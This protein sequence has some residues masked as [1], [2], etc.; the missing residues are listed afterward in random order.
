[1]NRNSPAD[2]HG[3]SQRGEA[4]AAGGAGSVLA[5]VEPDHHAA[6]L[7]I[8]ENPLQIAAEPLRREKKKNLRA[9]FL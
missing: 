2:E 8:L 3:G 7:Q 9:L 1:M 6:L 4:L 5:R